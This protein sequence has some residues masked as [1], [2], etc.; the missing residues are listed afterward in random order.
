MIDTHSHI[1]LKDFDADRLAVIF[2]AKN[3]GVEHII[4]PNVDSST[5]SAM[6]ELEATEPQ[7]FHA[8]IGLH[9]TSVKANYADELALIRAELDNRNYC[10][11]G[12]IGL[13]LYWDKSFFRE[14]LIVFEQQLQWAV[15][16]NLPVIIHVREA[17]VEVFEVVKKY[18]QDLKGIFHSFGGTVDEARQIMSLNNFKMGINGIITF[19]NSSLSET[20][21][22]VPLE[23]LVLETDAPYLTP[24]PHRGKRNEPA[25]LQ[26]VA[27]RLA[28]IYQ[29]S[30]QEISE[31]TTQNAKSIFSRICE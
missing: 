14:Q 1:Y 15:E 3:A 12:E 13:D 5:L 2:R 9:P 29:I 21:S 28:E 8:A 4:L 10:A 25:F 18:Q 11:M 31:I 19:K 16:R 30:E 22:Q 20:L 23:Y 26:F 6:L 17:F 7:F 27:Q 24:V